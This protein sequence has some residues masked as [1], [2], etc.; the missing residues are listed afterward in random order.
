MDDVD[1]VAPRA[2]SRAWIGRAA[3]EAGLG[4]AKRVER[5]LDAALQTLPLP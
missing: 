2:R 5:R 1:E 4:H 3:F